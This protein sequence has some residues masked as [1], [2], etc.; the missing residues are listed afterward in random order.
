MAIFENWPYTN[1]HEKNLDWIISKIKEFSERLGSVEAALAAL[2]DTIDQDVYNIMVEWL[3]DGTLSG[4]ISGALAN[5]EWMIEDINTIPAGVTFSIGDTVT[6]NTAIYAVVG[7]GLTFGA[8]QLYP[9]YYTTA[10]DLGLKG[11]GLTE[12]SVKLQA[13]YNLL[14]DIDLHGGKVLIG[15]AI[16]LKSNSAIRNGA[17]VWAATLGT[18][19]T[20][21]SLTNITFDGIEF[22]CTLSS[23]LGKKIS[24]TNSSNLVIKKCYMHNWY[25]TFARLNGSENCQIMDCRTDTSTGDTGDDGAWFYFQGG[26]NLKFSNLIGKD[27]S[28]VLIYLDGSTPVEKV[29]INNINAD[30][31]TSAVSPNVITIYGETNDVTINNVN[32]IDCDGG[33]QVAMRASKMP[34]HVNISNYNADHSK[35]HGIRIRNDN[36]TI[37]DTIVNITN[38][39][40]TSDQDG[41]ILD[42]VSGVTI[43]NAQIQVVRSC[44]RAYKSQNNI[45]SNCIFRFGD[46]AN[47]GVRMDANCLENL[48]AN[49]T[50][51]NSSATNYTALQDLNTANNPSVVICPVFKGNFVAGGTDVRNTVVLFPIY[52]G[53]NFGSASVLFGTG[54]DKPAYGLFD[55]VQLI[56]TSGTTSGWHRKTNA[57][58]AN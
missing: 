16:N 36:N 52:F 58:V 2:E 41:I 51:V 26:S 30:G 10:Q 21:D 47:T 12:E 8:Y 40:I 7:S 42:G 34:Q 32:A 13:A 54:T 20:G 5:K 25:G 46:S 1:F 22:D 9:L 37:E 53:S 23:V 57:W 29:V 39:F 4:L 27:Q 3:G 55:G 44:I 35:Y 18:G 50:F 15:S 6:T 49:C 43:T 48:I 28:G 11:D 56:D 45:I 24:L 38:V 14:S 33:I 31:F 19:F 17:I